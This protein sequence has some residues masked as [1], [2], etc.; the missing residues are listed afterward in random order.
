MG[1][2]GSNLRARV[3]LT[4]SPIWSARAARSEEI[5]IRMFVR[6]PMVDAYL[7]QVNRLYGGPAAFAKTGVSARTSARTSD[8][9]LRRYHDPSTSA[10]PEWFELD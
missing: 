2:F 7:A 1:V 10:L 6:R 4:G 8:G 5:L 3:V 9:L